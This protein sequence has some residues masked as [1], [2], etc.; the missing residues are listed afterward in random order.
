VHYYHAAKCKTQGCPGIVR[1]KYLG[2]EEDWIIDLSV[3]LKSSAA[4]PPLFRCQVCGKEHLYRV[5]EIHPYKFPD[6][7][8]ALF[9]NRI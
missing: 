3:H 1:L 6:P 5:E 8:V 2:P 9:R 7:P 4:N